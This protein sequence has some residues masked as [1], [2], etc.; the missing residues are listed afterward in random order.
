M[1]LMRSRTA[2]QPEHVLDERREHVPRLKVHE[3]ADE[4]EA[5]CRG[6]RDDDIAE[7]RIG[8]HQAVGHSSA[9]RPVQCSVA[10]RTSGNLSNRRGYAG[11]PGRRYSQRTKA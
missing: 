1:T 10:K 8:L 11:R 5:V 4:V 7:G 9:K 2:R 6:K 3:R